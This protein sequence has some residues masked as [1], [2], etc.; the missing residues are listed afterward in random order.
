MVVVGGHDS[1]SP[2]VTSARSWDCHWMADIVLNGPELLTLRFFPPHNLPRPSSQWYEVS[3]LLKGSWVRLPLLSQEFP[4]PRLSPSLALPL[5][6]ASL[7]GPG[8][9]ETLG[10]IP[11]PEWTDL[12]RR[13]ALLDTFEGK[14]LFLLS[15][16]Q[17]DALLHPRDPCLVR[18]ILNDL[19]SCGRW[20]PQRP[21]PPQPRSSG[22]HLLTVLLI[23]EGAGGGMLC[24]SP[25]QGDI[26]DKRKFHPVTNGYF[27][28]IR[29]GRSFLSLFNLASICQE[30]TEESLW[31]AALDAVGG[32][33]RARFWVCLG[34][35]A[36]HA[37]R[38]PGVG[39]GS[40][41]HSLILRGEW[42][43]EQETKDK[44]LDTGS[45]RPLPWPSLQAAF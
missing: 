12:H 31:P 32:L 21:Q 27:P 11:E 45:R 28:P 26:P 40:G 23:A 16:W 10:S 39:G 42:A 3:C 19:I 30:S 13:R 38:F 5:A 44:S 9:G 36:H 35:G 37:G 4:P 33:A 15:P 7:K 34:A 20:S 22:V 8:P 29:G 25:P 2:Q 24:P 14:A 1:S 41:A 17:Q 43:V 18:V 6:P